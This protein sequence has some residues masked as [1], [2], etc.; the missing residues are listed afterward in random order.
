[1]SNSAAV[2]I[3]GPW[4]LGYEYLEKEFT[5]LWP[6]VFQKFTKTPNLLIFTVIISS[7]VALFVR[8]WNQNKRCGNTSWIGGWM[9]ERMDKR[10]NG[11]MKE[12]INKQ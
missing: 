9:N 12:W 3:D 8:A 1:M 4:Q 6:P 11:Q 5:T 10:M 7:F 2:V